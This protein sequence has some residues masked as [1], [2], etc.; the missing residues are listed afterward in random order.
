MI[1]NPTSIHPHLALDRDRV[2]SMAGQPTTIGQ[3]RGTLRL[4]R[5]YR[6]FI[7]SDA[8]QAKI[9]GDWFAT[10]MTRA[11]AQRRLTEMVLVAIQRKGWAESGASD[12]V[13]REERYRKWNL[14][15]QGRMR[16]DSEKINNHFSGRQPCRKHTPSWPDN[17]EI[18]ER[19]KDQFVNDEG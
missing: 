14:E 10:T 17:V 8:N 4:L 5:W 11:E 19:F 12:A 2:I 1:H 7:R 3:I 18:V 13:K 9:P 16:R 15:W 6:A